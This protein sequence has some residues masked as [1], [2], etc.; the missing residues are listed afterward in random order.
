M[1][2]LE[3]FDGGLIQSFVLH[4]F[5]AED[6]HVRRGRSDPL[7]DSGWMSSNFGYGRLLE[8]NFGYV[9]QMVDVMGLLTIVLYE[10]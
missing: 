4:V 6:D 5:S 10:V 8:W 9:Q 1:R 7:Q 3:A 2:C